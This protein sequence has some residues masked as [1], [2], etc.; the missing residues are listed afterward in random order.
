[1]KI[2]SLLYARMIKM[3]MDESGQSVHDIVDE[4][5]LHYVTVQRYLRDLHQEEAV[6]IKA[7]QK[8]ARG[9][10]A[11]KVYALGPGRD[12]R[13]KKLT[14]AER[15]ARSRHKRA[16]LELTH[17]TAGNGLFGMP[18]QAGTPPT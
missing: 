4:L 17:R 12:A 15:Q 9:R 3:L 6:H 14:T 13:R 16:M 8:D 10:D 5:G 1:V 2:N 18:D 11:I 7:W